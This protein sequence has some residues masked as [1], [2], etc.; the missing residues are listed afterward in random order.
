MAHDL[1]PDLNLITEGLGP[2]E[3]SLISKDITRSEVNNG[4]GSVW[5]R[6]V[7][8]PGRGGEESRK[9]EEGRAVDYEN[10]LGE[11]ENKEDERRTGPGLSGDLTSD[12]ATTRVPPPPGRGTETDSPF[13]RTLN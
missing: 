12:G 8:N 5:S 1:H 11:G 3:I 7:P 13:A 9:K 10:N 6:V 2:S 4:L